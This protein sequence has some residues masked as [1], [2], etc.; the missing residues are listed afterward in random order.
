MHYVE[1][2]PRMELAQIKER[3]DW[4]AITAAGEVEVV[5][6]IPNGEMMTQSLQLT[7]DKTLWGR[8]WWFVCPAGCGR[9]C[10]HLYIN[11]DGA[12]SCRGCWGSGK[13]LLYYQQALPVR[14]RETVGVHVLRCHRSLVPRSSP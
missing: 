12:L 6:R 5:L 3:S 14:F 1:D 11:R 7:S 4:A 2:T 13:G 9:R 10:L 8:R